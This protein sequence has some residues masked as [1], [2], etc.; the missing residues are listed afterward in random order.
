VTPLFAGPLS[1]LET[2][3]EELLIWIHQ[4]TNLSWAW[5]IVVLTAIVRVAIMPVTVKQTRSMLAMQVLQPYIKQ[6]Q[7]RY[8]DDR[9]VLNEKIMGFYRDNKVNP[10][11]SCLPILL[12]IPI[13]TALF[14]VLKDFQ[15]SEAFKEANGSQDFSFLFGF[16]NDITTKVSEGGWE[17]IALLAFYV[18]SQMFSSLVMMTSPDPKQKYIFMALPLVFIPFIWNF[19]IGLMLYWISTNLWTLGQHVVV[20]SI[21]KLP[22]EV[23]LPPD[24]KGVS[25]VIALKGGK[26]AGETTRT[27]KEPKST[28]VGKASG[29]S[30]PKSP[31]AGNGASRPAHARKNKRRR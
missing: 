10:L 20:K 30:T 15:N 31:S 9:K 26:A 24:N 25:R 16:I 14:F 17:A 8:K 12:Q 18:L 29:G 27:V 2:P 4:T 19:P 13:F 23:V 28:A 7:E 1:F 5:S 21:T 6:L 3:L 22:S 11:A